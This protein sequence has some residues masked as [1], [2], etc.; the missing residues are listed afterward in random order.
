[1][2]AKLFSFLVFGVLNTGT[3]AQEGDIEQ[4]LKTYVDSDEL[5][6]ELTSEWQ[7]EDIEGL[8][9]QIVWGIKAAKGQFIRSHS[10][11][12]V[13]PEEAIQLRSDIKTRINA[14]LAAYFSGAAHSHHGH[15][16]GEDKE[17]EDYALR[18]LNGPCV[19]M[20]FEN[21]D[22]T[23][24]DMTEGDVDGNPFGYVNVTSTTAWGTGFPAGSAAEQHFIVNGGT[25]PVV[26][27]PMVNP[28]TGSCSA[29][30]GD[31]T[32]TGYRAAS[33]SQPF[34]V[35]ATNA[36]Y[37]YH[38]AVVLQDPAHTV[39]EQPFFRIRMY[40]EL[41][42]SIPC[43]EYDVYAGNGDPAWQSTGGT[44]FIDW[45][46]AFIPLQAYIGQ[47]VTI[48]FTVGD[49]DQGGHYGYAYV[50]GSCSAMEIIPSDT[51]VC[52][53]QPVTLTAPAGGASYTWSNG[54]TTQTI[55]VTSGGL[56][57]VDV[58]AVSG[59][60]ISLD[61]MVYDGDAP[62][63]DFVSTV[64]CL[65]TPTDFTDQSFGPN[66]VS[67]WAW[68]FDNNGTVD[69]TTTN[70]SY[71]FGS[72]GTFPVNLEITDGSGCVHDTILNVLVEDQPVADFTSTAVCE[73][74]ITSFTDQSI[75]TSGSIDTWEWDFDSNGSIDN[76][77]PNPTNGYPAAGSYNAT[78]TVTT[79][80]G[81]TDNI[82]YPV[83]VNPVPV[84][85][86][87]GTDVCVGNVTTFTDLSV[88]S[89]G[90]ITA[91]QWD[92][93]DGTGT[94]AVQNPGYTYAASG[95]YNVQLTVTSASGCI[96]S[97]VIQVNVY[98]QPIADFT[99]TDVCLS[100]AA[101]FTDLSL[102][103]GGAATSGWEWDVDGDGVVDYT[104]QNPTHA[105][106]ADGLYNPTLIL[107]SA[108]G[109]ADTVSYPLTIYPMPV[110]DYAFT[111]VCLGLD[112]PFADNSGVT[113]G[114]IAG[115]NWNFGNG[116]TSAVQ[117]PTELYAA[118]G[119]YDVQLVVVSD[120]GC[121]DSI[122]QTIE[123]WPIPVPDF[124]L[125]A[126][127]EGAS[128]DFTDLS[129][130]SSAYTPNSINQWQWDFGDG[131]ISALANAT[132]V[133]GGA[134]SYTGMLTV[135]TAN[136]CIDSVPVPVT[137]HPNPVIN[138]TSTD[139]DGCTVWC[140]D[141]TNDVTIGSGSITDYLWDF[142]DGTIST[143]ADPQHCYENSTQAP[144]FFDVSL[145]ATSDQGCISDSTSVAMITV[146]PLPIAEFDFS[147]T[148][149]D[150]YASTVNFVDASTG[151]ATWD[152]D[153]GDGD[154]AWVT[155]PEHTYADA[156]I[157]DITLFITNIYGCTDEVTHSLEVKP[158]YGI[159]VPN[160]F[161]P[162]GDG[163]NDMFYAEGFNI[164]EFELFIFDRWGNLIYEA[165]DMNRGWDG[166]RHGDLVQEDVYVWKVNATDIFNE[167]HELYGHVTV[168]R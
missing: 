93:G 24:W 121:L 69:N 91:W 119:V 107:T 158:D 85:D 115:W 14:K 145:T 55:S 146:Y 56:Y 37:T 25:D 162:N 9:S 78:L 22:Y 31:G 52:A 70:P 138:F 108:A 17:V 135:T 58:A 6:A 165:E 132:H 142:G 26:G 34:L 150:V 102:V 79:S 48:E 110:A 2:K 106:G 153:F 125:S 28:L 118:E 95:S 143:N 137:V 7:E 104:N 74:T 41:G 126:V 64:G 117:N 20:D 62:T 90:S 131:S 130:V 164:Q 33:I 88:I 3:F 84:A 116:S 39:G 72:A 120:N 100:E 81:C 19:N 76:T 149:L 12:T 27:I 30:I 129:T 77:S 83:T 63:A 32:G 1:M 53:G 92:F 38:Y 144:A 59:C 36:N 114:T 161:T 80:A 147:P 40:D 23:G 136:G 68:D 73:G 50:E 65:G 109:C 49:C 156:G 122:M 103:G 167:K 46:T 47:N 42:N 75:M 54:A 82:T 29:L 89:S 159:Y 13:T 97:T 160:A 124:T 61:V 67:N 105:F 98:E 140:V 155:N 111:N 166:R 11:L 86:F 152:W 168:V 127:C 148:E 44:D 57:S 157:Y 60:V 21:C 133:Y 45:Q 101:Q 123:V 35:D 71:T 128:T 51:I 163:Y 8:E 113:G 141:F 134:G 66:G 43:A 18:V 96:N 5:L 87:S 4:I 112:V 15:E 139:P 99:V 151:S 154:S 10:E 16:Q 94:S